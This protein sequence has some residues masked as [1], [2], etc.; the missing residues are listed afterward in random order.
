MALYEKHSFLILDQERQWP[1]KLFFLL[2]G[3]YFFL[4]IFI[5]LSEGRSTRLA[6]DKGIYSVFTMLVTDYLAIKKDEIII[7][8]GLIKNFI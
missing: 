1:A 7:R 6:P 8:N 2:L 3:L 5:A 4:I